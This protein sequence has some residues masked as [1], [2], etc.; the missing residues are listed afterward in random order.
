MTFGVLIDTFVTEKGKTVK[1]YEYLR[2]IDSFKMMNSS[3]EKLVEILPDDRFKIMRAMFST[4][5]DA[6]LQLL[7][8]KGY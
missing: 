6:N 2:F 4:L 3:L 5:S 7:K 8:Q 1:V